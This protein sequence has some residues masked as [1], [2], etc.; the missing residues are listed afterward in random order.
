MRNTFFTKLCP[1]LTRTVNP[2][3]SKLF[4]FEMKIVIQILTRAIFSL[5]FLTFKNLQFSITIK[6]LVVQE[7]RA[8]FYFNIFSSVC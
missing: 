1:S 4:T 7:E 3:L 8:G 6:A 2:K 5:L